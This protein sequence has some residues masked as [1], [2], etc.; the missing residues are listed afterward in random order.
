MG[1]RCPGGA[2][3]FSFLGV[4]FLV[5]ALV[6]CTSGSSDSNATK[7]APAAASSVSAEPLSCPAS[8]GRGGTFEVVQAVPP[9][10]ASNV[11]PTTLL[12]LFF[13]D[14]MDAASFTSASIKV[15]GSSS[16]TVKTTASC[17]VTAA[18]NT[19]VG[20]ANANPGGFAPGETVTV[21]LA[22]G[23]LRSKSGAQSAAF[24]SNFKIVPVAPAAYPG[25]SLMFSSSS[26]PAGVSC[27][28][29]CGVLT[30]AFGSAPTFD[31]NALAYVG[32][33]ASIGAGTAVAGTTSTLAVSGLAADGNALTFDYRLISAEFP[34]YIGSVFDD[35]F[36]V[37]IAGPKGSTLKLV[38]SV[39]VAGASLSSLKAGTFGPASTPNAVNLAGDGANAMMTAP[40]TGTVFVASLGSPLT[41]AFVVSDIGD[42]GFDTVIQLNNIRFTDGTVS[43]ATPEDAKRLASPASR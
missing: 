30:G 37:T 41:V 8:D 34:N 4:G 9:L 31:S 24:A 2:R 27:E 40:L 10:A 35:T 26:L 17:L 23:A 19:V 20:L 12:V 11:H 13:S 39:N 32:T 3:R 36:L 7:D 16:G 38:N 28:G 18:K 22:A 33:G 6:A 5:L 15:S 43:S 14:A 21:S 1:R 42:T 25:S 29:D